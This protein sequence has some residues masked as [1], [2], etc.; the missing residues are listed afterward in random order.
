MAGRF[1]PNAIMPSGYFSMSDY[2]SAPGSDLRTADYVAEFYPSRAWRWYLMAPNVPPLDPR[3]LRYQGP[4]SK[5]NIWERIGAG[6]WV[7]LPDAPW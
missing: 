7:K 5:N 1:N 4:G 2:N 6:V 3:T